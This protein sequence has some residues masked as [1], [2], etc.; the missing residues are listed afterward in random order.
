MAKLAT[1]IVLFRLDTVALDPISQHFSSLSCMELEDGILISSPHQ[2]DKFS[3][4][5]GGSLSEEV[6]CPRGLLFNPDTQACDLP[7]NVNCRDIPLPPWMDSPEIDKAGRCPKE[8]PED[9]LFL[10]VVDDCSP[11]YIL[12]FHG[13][14]ISMSCYAGQYWNAETTT[15]DKP[16]NV[17]CKI[18][19]DTHDCPAVGIEFL[20]HPE[21][22]GK[23]IYC[24]D[25]FAR[26][27]RCSFLKVF[28][29]DKKA[30][31][32]GTQC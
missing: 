24:R 13:R 25:G 27:Q 7:V 6:S 20:P 8:D 30:C 23:F 14:E 12:C 29:K 5:G 21:S 1:L 3:Y 9:P 28:D 22:C 4:C 11:F 16:E 10:P 17:K 18:N 19:G 31:V 32:Y 26:L 15:C 2:C